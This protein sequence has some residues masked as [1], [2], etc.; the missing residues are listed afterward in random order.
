MDCDGLAPPYLFREPELQSG[1]IA[2]LPTI[3]IKKYP[4]KYLKL[5]HIA[6]KAILSAI[7]VQGQNT[8]IATIRFELIL[9]SF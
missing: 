7:G 6:S 1:A 5:Q 4:W 2:T 9:L 3:L 8:K